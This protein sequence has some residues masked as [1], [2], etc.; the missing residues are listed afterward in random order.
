[1]MPH[2]QALDAGP[3]G[4]GWASA[5]GERGEVVVD[6]YEHYEFAT[7]HTAI[8]ALVLPAVITTVNVAGFPRVCAL[9]IRTSATRGDPGK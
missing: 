8:T 6:A 1:M 2:A 9:S 7:W 4:F 3:D 5:F